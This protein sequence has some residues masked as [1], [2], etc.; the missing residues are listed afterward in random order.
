MR[1][2]TVTLLLPED[3]IKQA[4]D[5]AV[6]KG[7]TLSGLISDSLEQLLLVEN[8]LKQTNKLNQDLLAADIDR[9]VNGD[10]NWPDENAKGM[11]SAQMLMDFLVNDYYGFDQSRS[12]KHPRRKS[13]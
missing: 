9:A 2:E 3:L 12:K 8:T 10:S 4:K 11:T 13:K 6:E 5:L 7:T 1:K